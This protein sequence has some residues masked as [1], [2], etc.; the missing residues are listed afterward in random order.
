MTHVAACMNAQGAVEA[1]YEHG[2]DD[3]QR[4]YLPPLIAGKWMGTMN[5]TEP[6]AGSDLAAVRATAEPRGDGT[7]AIKGAKI[8]ITYG[9]HDLTENII[10]LVLARL[11]GAPQGTRGISLFLAPK[12]L[13]N[14]DGSPG[15]RNDVVCAGLE[16]KLGIHVSATCVMAFGEN[17][18]A[19]GWLLGEENK[20]LACMFTMMNNA[21]LHVGIQG[22]AIAERS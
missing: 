17:G 12:F 1:I 10:H 6:Q 5:L 9:D 3:L 16:H 20:G 19:T 11:P 15:D 18:G 4:K 14:E 2:S 8:F 13:L 22:V 7:Y 21:R